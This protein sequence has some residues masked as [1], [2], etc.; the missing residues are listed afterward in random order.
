[1]EISSFEQA[2]ATFRT[3]LLAVRPDQLHEPTPC[4]PLDV[5]QLVTRA[6]GHQNWVRSALA[7]I[8]ASR[9]Y[10]RVDPAHFV[11]EFDQSTEAM[12]D[13][14]Q[15]DGAM[16]RTVALAGSLTFPGSDVLTL[17]T[18]NIFQFAWDLAR[19]T[20]QSTD[21]APELAGQLLDVSRTHLVPQRGP[22]GFF[23]PEYRPCIDSTTAD[24]L[25]GFLGR[26]L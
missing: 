19:A 20:G 4:E 11:S 26:E 24:E 10:P 21:L 14:L 5:E 7:G 1:M 16:D 15:S 12:V 2:A 8:A 23:G 18:R 9:E 6:I 25:A 3:V 13:E 22:D 17:A